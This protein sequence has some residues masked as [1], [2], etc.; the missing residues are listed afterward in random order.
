MKH[1][2]ITTPEQLDIYVASIEEA[3]GWGPALEAR[4]KFLAKTTPDFRLAYAKAFFAEGLIQA[5]QEGQFYARVCQVSASGM[6]RHITLWVPYIDHTGTVRIENLTYLLHHFCG[7]RWN[8][9]TNAVIVG[10]CGM[11][12]IFH[13]IDMFLHK[14]ALPARSPEGRQ[15]A[16][17]YHMI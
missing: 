1:S 13:T 4:R 17:D 14:L 7:Y 2:E 5:L 16:S 9:D 10:G 6:S 12:M 15:R 3:K 8:K 11:D